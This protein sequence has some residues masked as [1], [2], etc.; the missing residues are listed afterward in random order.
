MMGRLVFM[1][2]NRQISEQSHQITLKLERVNFSFEKLAYS[3][4]CNGSGRNINW[5]N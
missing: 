3:R 5:Y 4:V 2:T 1:G